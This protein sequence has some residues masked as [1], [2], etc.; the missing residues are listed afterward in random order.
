MLVRRRGKTKWTKRAEKSGP[1][2]L[3]TVGRHGQGTSEGGAEFSKDA[4]VK[5]LL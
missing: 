3:P 2:E 4:T 1:Q 5:T